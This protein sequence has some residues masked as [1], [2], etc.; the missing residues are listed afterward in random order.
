MIIYVDAHRENRRSEADQIESEDGEKENWNT[1]WESGQAELCQQVGLSDAPTQLQDGNDTVN[2]R[3]RGKETADT[4][5][6]FSVVFS[7]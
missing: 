3:A 2:I 7:S 4:M 1:F 5:S 6:Y